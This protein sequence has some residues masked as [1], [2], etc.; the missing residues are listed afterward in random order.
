MDL[1]KS[2]VNVKSFIDS[3][4]S[5]FHTPAR[6]KDITIKMELCDQSVEASLSV[7]KTDSISFDKFKMSQVLRNFMSNAMKFTPDG[8]T[9]TVR[10]CFTPDM[11]KPLVAIPSNSKL[12]VKQDSS[13]SVSPLFRLM[14]LSTKSVIAS[15]FDVEEGY[16]IGSDDQDVGGGSGSRRLAQQGMLRI[17]VIDSGAGISLENQKRLFTEIVQFNPEVLQGGGGSGFGL[18]ICN[19]IVDLHGG[20]IDVFSEGTHPLNACV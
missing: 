11:S 6:G 12:L 15:D 17:S 9:I 3:C 20:S 19:G 13:K 7:N 1:H 5:I 18:Y 8:G 10:A 16:I 14:S 2:D 4:L